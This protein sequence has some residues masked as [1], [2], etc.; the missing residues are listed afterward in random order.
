MERDCVEEQA[1]GAGRAA[2]KEGHFNKTKG[3]DAD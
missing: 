3:V 1:E 2:A